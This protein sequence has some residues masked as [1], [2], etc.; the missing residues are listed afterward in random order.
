MDGIW[1]MREREKKESRVTPKFGLRN[2][3][4]GVAVNFD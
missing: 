4:N 3:K 1:G 2:L